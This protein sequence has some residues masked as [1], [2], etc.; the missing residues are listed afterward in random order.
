[1][2]L[3]MRMKKKFSNIVADLALTIIYGF[4]IGYLI[5]VMLGGI[6]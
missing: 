3:N 4:A 5:C 1:M 6:K 2:L